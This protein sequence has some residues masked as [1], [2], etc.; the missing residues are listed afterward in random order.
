MEKTFSSVMD[1]VERT[2]PRLE[3]E[4]II[5]NLDEVGQKLL[6]WALDP[7]ITFGVTVND[8]TKYLDISPCLC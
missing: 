1:E 6:K 8:D 5:G 4:R 2:G 7:A 3:K